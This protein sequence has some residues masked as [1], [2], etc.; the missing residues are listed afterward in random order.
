MDEQLVEIA[1]EDCIVVHA[2]Q[3]DRELVDVPKIALQ[4]VRGPATSR[5]MT[6]LLQWWRNLSSSFT[7]DSG[8]QRILEKS[9]ETHTV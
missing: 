8:Q 9:L 2:P 6:F 4:L 3:M 1:V 5:L 7:L